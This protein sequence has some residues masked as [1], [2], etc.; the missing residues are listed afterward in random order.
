LRASE[1]QLFLGGPPSVRPCH[2]AVLRMTVSVPWSRLLQPRHLRRCQ[3]GAWSFP[4]ESSR[5]IPFE[6][7]ASCTTGDLVKLFKSRARQYLR[8]DFAY[9]GDTMARNR[10]TILFSHRPRC[11]SRVRGSLPSLNHVRRNRRPAIKVG[12]SGLKNPTNRFRS[13]VMDCLK[14]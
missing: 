8:S 4:H 10:E 1:Y 9:P 13:E 12:P 6:N 7:R 5:H 3:R 14:L 2:R 11:S